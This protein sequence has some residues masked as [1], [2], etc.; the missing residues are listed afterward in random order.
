VI[1]H[2]LIDGD[3]LAYRCAFLNIGDRLDLLSML[4]GTVHQWQTE[5]VSAF[6]LKNPQVT[7]C[8]SKFKQ[9]NFRHELYPQYKHI[10]KGRTLPDDLAPSYQI[11][12]DPSTIGYPY[13]AQTGLEADDIMGIL[14]TAYESTVIVT[15]D[16]DLQSIPGRHY[17]PVKQKAVIVSPE[18]ANHNFMTQW[19]TGD[20]TDCV[21][22]MYR[23]GPAKAAKILSQDGNKEDLVL[24]AYEKAGY[25]YNY[26]VQQG[27]LVKIL[28]NQHIIG[29]VD[30]AIE[31]QSWQPTS[32]YRW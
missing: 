15:V 31:Y 8:L 30:T 24:Q 18:Q 16:K 23:V 19:L 7:L 27:Q 22:G 10:R 2:I 4:Q 13:R 1:D 14:G 29:P 17:N 28:D 26:C 21:P 11:L 20:A 32:T 12:E 6:D 25:S 5:V 9:P 3:Y